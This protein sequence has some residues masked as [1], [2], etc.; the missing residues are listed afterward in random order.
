MGMCGDENSR[1]LG[2]IGLHNK[3]DW[4]EHENVCGKSTKIVSLSLL[5]MADALQATQRWHHDASTA[6]LLHA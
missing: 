6:A 5:A 2:A 3:G 1:D 4:P